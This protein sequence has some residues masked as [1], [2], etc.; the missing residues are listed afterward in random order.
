MKNN[1]FPSFAL[2][3]GLLF[4]YAFL[5]LCTTGLSR[6]LTIEDGLVETLSA[7]FYFIAGGLM[8]LL[9]LKD[10]PV[11]PGYLFG[12]R[13][14]SLYL[15]LSIFFGVCCGEEISWGQRILH[16]TTPQYLQKVNLQHEI[17]L[18]NLMIFNGNGNKHSVKGW[19]ITVVFSANGLYSLVWSF[20]G[21]V[22]PLLARLSGWVKKQTAQVGLPVFPLRLGL[23]FVLNFGI[24]KL[25]SALSFSERDNTPLVELKETLIA[26]LYAVGSLQVLATYRQKLAAAKQPLTRS[27]PAKKKR[28]TSA[29]SNPTL[30]ASR[31]G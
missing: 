12:W 3:C 29:N 6:S 11:R 2:L 21:F 19:L 13:S 16:V 7:V 24:F 15:L 28:A 20:Y 8:L 22:L 27:R 26:L 14:N 31:I 25:F 5:S 23:L 10:R 4:S 9:F 17:N 30:I 1:Y 18:H